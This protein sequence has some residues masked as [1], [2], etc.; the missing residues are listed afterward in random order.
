MD[1]WQCVLH[2]AVGLGA[3]IFPPHTS[4]NIRSHTRCDKLR[5]FSIVLFAIK[6]ILTSINE[7]AQPVFCQQVGR[8]ELRWFP[9]VS[10]SLLLHR[11]F[12][13]YVFTVVIFLKSASQTNI[14]INSRS[15]D[16]G[17]SE[18]SGYSVV[19]KSKFSWS[20]FQKFVFGKS[21]HIHMQVLAWSVCY[22]CIF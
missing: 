8:F 12:L 6:Y 9:D 11:L 10:K 13:Y 7:F 5:L 4:N 14:I 1:S 2:P 18:N 19:L 3:N 15:T 17:L 16:I 21:M 22:N 20:H